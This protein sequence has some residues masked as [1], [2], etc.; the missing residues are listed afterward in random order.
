MGQAQTTGG[1]SMSPS[2]AAAVAAASGA[3]AM[4]AAHRQAAAQA[5]M[6]QR[7]IAELEEAKQRMRAQ[8]SPQATNQ[9]F[10]YPGQNGYPQMA[11]QA[12]GYQ[13]V[14]PA[15]QAVPQAASQAAPTMAGGSSMG[16]SVMAQRAAATRPAAVAAPVP[17]R[18]AA[19]AQTTTQPV[20]TRSSG[21]SSEDA[22]LAHLGCNADGWLDMA[23]FARAQ[24]LSQSGCSGSDLPVVIMAIDAMCL[25]RT[26]RMPVVQTGIQPAG[27]VAIGA[28]AGSTAVG[29]SIPW[30]LIITA[31]V[32]GGAYWYWKKKDR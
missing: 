1:P 5:A 26:N 30:W 23:P 15:A 10:G 28:A 16:G 29:V 9:A 17:V 18:P 11:A 27:Q 25:K 7:L 12:P 2:Q 21:M 6:S 8:V 13:Y 3:E 20:Q 14:A 22:W 31:A 24:A 19:Q 4:V 32:A